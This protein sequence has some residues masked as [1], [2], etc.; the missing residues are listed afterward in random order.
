[1]FTVSRHIG[2][3]GRRFVLERS[4]VVRSP[5]VV[6]SLFCVEFIGMA[7]GEVLVS[8]GT[9]EVDESRGSRVSLFEVL[10]FVLEKY[11]C[12]GSGTLSARSSELAYSFVSRR[13]LLVGFCVDIIGMVVGDV[14][15]LYM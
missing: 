2:N 15:C 10:V 3:V 7:V 9:R 4:L 1:M 5:V 8:L 11:G 13:R 6:F 14:W 12:V